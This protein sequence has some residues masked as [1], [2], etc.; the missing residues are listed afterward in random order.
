MARR[1]SPIPSTTRTAPPP[2]FPR[3]EPRRPA[4][5][6]QSVALPASVPLPKPVDG[7]SPAW[8]LYVIA[9][10]QVE[11]V[12]AALAKAGVGYK[13]YYRTPVH[14]QAPMRQWA[15]DVQL[16]ATERA[17]DNHLAIPMSPVLTREHVDEVVSAVREACA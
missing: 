11:R 15:G 1:A 17:A 4:R 9:H 7:S 3:D 14:L 13:A 12:E 6:P 10:P 5:R 8:H 2:P 16:P